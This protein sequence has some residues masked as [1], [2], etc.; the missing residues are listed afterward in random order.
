MKDEEAVAITKAVRGLSIKSVRFYNNRI[1]KMGAEEMSK[2]MIQDESL[3]EDFDLS[4]NLIGPDFPIALVHIPRIKK[5]N[6]AYNKLERI[7]VKLLD[8]QAI[9]DRSLDIK[10]EANW[11]LQEPPFQV[12]CMGYDQVLR[13]LEDSRE[14]R[15][16]LE[17]I[18]TVL[19][20]KAR[21]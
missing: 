6:V 13:W 18:S 15:R 5:L 12:A 20:E 11:K 9:R 3:L 4:K 7:S 10:L 19:G 2:I 16:A 8:I 21:S 1:T 14:K 17:T